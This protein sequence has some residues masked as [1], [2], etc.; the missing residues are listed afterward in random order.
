MAFCDIC[1]HIS[2]FTRANLTRTLNVRGMDIQVPYRAEVCINCGEARYDDGLEMLILEKASAI[3]RDKQHMLPAERI[4]SY[5]LR[6][7][8][9]AVEMANRA[10]CAVEDILRAEK[11]R[12]V[13]VEADKK[14]RNVICA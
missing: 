14:L 8:I 5:M 11:G 10:G 2:S 12:L 13:D 9:S 6:N 4:R 7:K 1:G 3:Y